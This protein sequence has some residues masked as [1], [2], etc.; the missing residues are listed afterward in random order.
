M[1]WLILWGAL[2]GARPSLERTWV[3][4]L[5]TG[6]LL[7]FVGSDLGWRGGRRRVFCVDLR[8]LSAPSLLCR[9]GVGRS[10]VCPPGLPGGGGGGGGGGERLALLSVSPSGGLDFGPSAGPICA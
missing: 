4:G 2:R 9:S 1:L 10:S 6:E 8:S 5:G 3:W 7:L